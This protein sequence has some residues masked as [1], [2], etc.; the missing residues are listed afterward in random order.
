MTRDRH[1]LDTPPDTD[2]RD[3]K[4]GLGVRIVKAYALLVGFVVLVAVA[5]LKVR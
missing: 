3:P 4:D 5:Y 1:E 2:D